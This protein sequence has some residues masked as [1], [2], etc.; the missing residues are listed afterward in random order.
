M[1]VN[2]KA[3]FIRIS[4]RKVRL[5]VDLVRGLKVTEAL[6]LL[7]H[8]PKAAARPVKKL[9]ES[10]VA[11]AEHNY[12]LAKADLVVATITA[13]D[14]PT[15]KRWMPR[16]FGRATQ[17]RKRMTHIAVTLSD[18]TDTVVEPV[19]REAPAPIDATGSKKDEQKDAAAKPAQDKTDKQANTS[20]QKQPAADTA[21]KE[22]DTQS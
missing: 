3:R 12:N 2:A 15:L 22:S 17:L 7:Q 11:N 13:D 10:A 20:D 16:A 6:T 1:Q 18:G 8:S 19:K 14:G 21:A 5:V 9:I 4:P